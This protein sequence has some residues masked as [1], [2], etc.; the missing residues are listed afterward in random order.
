MKKQIQSAIRVST[1]VLALATLLPLQQATAQQEEEIEEILVTGS[2]IKRTGATAP[3][4]VTIIGEEQ[5]S[6]AG[7]VNIANMLNQLPALGSTFTNASSSGFIGTVGLSFLDLRRLGTDR[8]L[9]LVDGRRHVAGQAGTAAIDINSIP[10]ELI[11][12]VE[13]VTGG[14]SA[15]YGAD[16]VSGVVNFI[17]KRDFEGVSLYG[18]GGNADEGDAFSWTTRGIIGSNFAEERG[19]AVLTFEVSSSDGFIGNDRSYDR[20]NQTFV[21]NPDDGD[22]P[23]NPN[24]GIPDQI[25]ID[26]AT[27]NFITAPGQFCDFIVT[28]NCWQPD[29]SGLLQPFDDG[30][31]FP[32]GVSRGGD[33]IRLSDISGS[34]NADIERIITTARVHYELAPVVTMFAEAKYVNAQSF[35]FNGTGAFD[36]FSLTIG[37]DYA[38]LDP[39][40]VQTV[41]DSGGVLFMSRTHQ[42]AERAE[43]AERQLFRGVFGFEGEFENGISYDLAYVYGR[44]TNQ[45]QQLNNRINERFFAGFDAVIDPMTNEPVCRFTIDPM[46]VNPADG[47]PFSSIVTDF[48]T[49]CVPINIMGPNMI[50]PEAVAW[51]HANGFL[52]EAVQQDVISLIFTG[53]SEAAGFSLPAGPIG[54]AA[55]FEYR[56]EKAESFPTSVDQL[57]LTFLNVIPP[58]SGQFDVTEWFGEVS[59][60]ILTDRP[61]FEELS[62][63]AAVR[64]ADYSTVGSTTTWKAGLS[65]SPIQDIRLR[66]TVSQA[67]RAPNISELFGPQSQTFLFFDDP[68]DVDF[69]DE[70]PPERAANCAALGLPPDFQQDDTRGNTPGTQGGNPNVREE[71]ADTVTVGLILTPSFLPNLSLTLD[72]WDVQIDDAISTPTLDDVLSN[73]VDGESIDNEFCPLITRDPTTGQVETFVI[74]NQNF[75]GIDAR[76]IDIELNYLLDTTSLGT[77]DFRL[78]ATRLDKLDLFPFQ[79]QPD[80]VDE[81]A[82]ELGD[83][84]WAANFNATWNWDKW[85]FNY[86]LRWLDSMLEVEIDELAA[87]PDLQSP[88]ET[89]SVVHHDIQIRYQAT[90]DIDAFVGVNNLTQEFPVH[91]L[92]GA[93]TDS[94]IFDNIGRFYYGGVRVNF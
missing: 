12:R 3:T 82:G 41:I 67:I 61:G 62:V 18:Q 17:M 88:I 59:V 48:A 50:S 15:I 2:R 42:E 68:C 30:E 23:A 6:L 20:R 10:Q 53:D 73:C 28:G 65:W 75:S 78:I 34:L 87:D 40:D 7:E 57:G 14:A 29:S 27:L 92:S 35:A 63:D 49:E 84:E 19:N 8:T 74:T 47:S 85:A 22:T 56:E 4:P 66:G 77:F 52:N 93:G 9:V 5:I 58:T 70:G 43:K 39:A 36:I 46:A 71:E 44:S 89:G 24:D 72:Y 32:S 25:L 64:F 60:P 69:L 38:F 54:W 86:E 55:G 91:G 37:P 26:N 31:I 1:L 45:V 16:A 94:A 21:F 79:S 83:P 81:E 11:E 33:G 90:D 13:V 80:F 51:S 76:G